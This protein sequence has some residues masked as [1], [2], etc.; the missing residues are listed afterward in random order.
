MV[1][2]LIK[3]DPKYEVVA[4]PYGWNDEEWNALTSEEQ[5]A[6]HLQ[7]KAQAAPTLTLTKCVTLDLASTLP[8]HI[9]VVFLVDTLA[10]TWY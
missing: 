2:D 1:V 4:R 3:R 9:I 10:T 7:T 5:K 8:S 6:T